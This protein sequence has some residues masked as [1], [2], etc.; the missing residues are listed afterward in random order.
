MLLEVSHP[1]ESA[2]DLLL[3]FGQLGKP[4]TAAKGKL[5]GF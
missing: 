4:F 2:R 3:S 1:A 5:W